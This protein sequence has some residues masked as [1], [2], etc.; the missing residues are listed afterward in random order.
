MEKADK[1][2]DKWLENKKLF[3]ET[4]HKYNEKLYSVETELTKLKKGQ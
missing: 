3:E 2:K 4:C 1:E